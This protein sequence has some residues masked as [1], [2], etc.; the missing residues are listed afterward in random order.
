MAMPHIRTHKPPHIILTPPPT[1]TT[2]NSDLNEEIH[3]DYRN[4]K[5][6]GSLFF[7]P[8]DCL[9]LQEYWKQMRKFELH[10]RVDPAA[11]RPFLRAE[12]G[13]Y[14][15]A[16]WTNVPPHLKTFPR[17]LPAGDDGAAAMH[18][19]PLAWLWLTSCNLSAGALGWKGILKNFEAGVLFHS[20][21][22]NFY[23]AWPSQPSSSPSSTPP[24]LPPGWPSTAQTKTIY[25]PLPFRLDAPH[26]TAQDDPWD[27][28]PD[29]LVPP[30][31]HSH[32]DLHQYARLKP[33]IPQIEEV[34][35]RVRDDLNELAA[36]QGL[37]PR[38]CP[39]PPQPPRPLASVDGYAEQ[40]REEKR[41][42]AAG[43]GDDEKG[44]GGRAWWC[45]YI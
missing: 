5:N 45:I 23:R 19:E 29:L 6:G 38:G 7:V 27:P 21:P 40:G 36:V 25:L 44:D 35:A 41:L 42:K 10:P 20:G 17:G 32:V 22:S 39:L 13:A 4:K 26:Y 8:E 1:N 30:Y 43:V 31:F 2:S 16:G 12:A 28:T 15:V 11:Q 14:G 9:D 24:P 34:F 33:L 3:V 18:G 37:D